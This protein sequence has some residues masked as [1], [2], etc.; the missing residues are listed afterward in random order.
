MGWLS[1]LFGIGEAEATGRELDAQL[2]AMN[3]RDYAPGG[4][5]YQKVAASD[6]VRAE[7]NWSVVQDHLASAKTGNVESQL[8]LSAVVGTLEWGYDPLTAWENTKEGGAIVGTVV[9]EEVAPA[10]GRVLETIGDA[11]GKVLFKVPLWVWIALLGVV[12]WQLGL[13]AVAKRR[14]EKL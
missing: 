3:E 8:I 7:Q 11:A 12:A 1:N 13:F 10:I 2:R 4:R 9:T 5:I 14:I 6:P